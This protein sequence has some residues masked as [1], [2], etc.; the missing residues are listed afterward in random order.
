MRAAG[1]AVRSTPIV[2]DPELYVLKHTKAPAV[3][4]E[5]GFHTNREE[6][7]LLGQPAYRQKLAEAEAKGILEYLGIPWTDDG[8]ETDYE[9][10]VRAAVAWLTENGIM[11]GNS[12]GDLML[13]QPLTRRQFAVMEYR[14]AKLE[15]FV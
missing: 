9:K 1:I 13:D 5:N 10:E 2:Y 15:G 7:A 6:A 11:R 3:L 14:I 12:Q 8:E 4:L